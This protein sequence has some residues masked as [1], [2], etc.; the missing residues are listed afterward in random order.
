MAEDEIP[1]NLEHVEFETKYRVADHLLIEFKQILEAHTELKG[2]VYV[3]GPDQ[4]FTYP[5]SWFNSMPQWDPEGTFIRYRKP[6]FGLDKGRRQVTWKYKPANS[7]NNI[8]RKEH[9]WDIGG[10]PEKVILEQIKDSGAIF[11]CSIV[12]NCHIYNFPDATLVFYTVYDT[13]FGKPE[14]ADYFVEIEVDESLIGSM[15]E[16]QAWAVIEKYEKVLAPI[17][18]SAQKRLKK[19]LF[20]MY[21]KEVK[22][23]NPK[24]D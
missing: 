15:S 22:N 7:K 6:S 21:R 11:N 2:F 20:Q 10:T 9:N 16:D 8:Q 3:E 17:G 13:T 12:K 5:D 23:G 24:A 14:E 19:S 1:D 18:I 4:F